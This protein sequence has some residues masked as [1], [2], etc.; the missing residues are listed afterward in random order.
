MSYE[1]NDFGLYDMAGNVAEWV[2]DVYRPIVDDEFNDFNYYRGNVYTENAINEDGTVQVVGV[3]NIKYDTLSTGRVV[4]RNLPGEIL[5]KPIT[6]DETYMRTNFSK[7]DNRDFRDGDKSSSRYYQPFQD[8]DNSKRMY[9]SPDFD[10]LAIGDTTQAK[11][12]YDD[13]ERTTLISDDVR[14]YKGGSWKDRAYWL[15]PA[16]RRFL[17]QDMATDYIGFR[18]AM[19]KVGAKSMDNVKRARSN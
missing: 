12:K 3:D 9:N 18:N 13:K 1:A 11:P 2:A 4:A 17:P 19:S 5:Q 10:R 8:T 14:V 16:Q 7:S 6:E 15:D